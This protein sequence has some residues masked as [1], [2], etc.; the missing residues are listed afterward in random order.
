MTLEEKIKIAENTLKQ[1]NGDIVTNQARLS[2]IQNEIARL[3]KN[4]ELALEDK[5][6]ARMVQLDRE[7]AKRKETQDKQQK[8]LDDYM[9]RID[10]KDAEASAKVIDVSRREEN[11]REVS[12][13][14]KIDI[15]QFNKN[16]NDAETARE[17]QLL[18]LNATTIGQLEKDKAQDL[19]EKNLGEREASF[20][21]TLK[22]IEDKIT[23]NTHILAKVEETLDEVRTVKIS[24][25]E[26][27]R[28]IKEN[29][30]IMQKE[31]QAIIQLSAIK[32][33]IAKFETVKAKFEEER[34][35]ILQLSKNIEARDKVVA[36][37]EITASEKE[38]YQS[39]RERQ[40]QSKI[41]L[42]QKL[43]TGE[44]S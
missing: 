38:K 21:A 34:A 8:Y 12:D 29:L 44:K 14:L 19:R 41:D 10:A 11:V 31:K 33:D 26:E 32:D 25:S 36:E 7:Q 5:A 27:S 9:V 28:V 42:L 1:V 23:E 3:I 24:I 2:G 15:E 16:L 43:R 39:I 6:I 22:T 20:E 17:K 13:R 18:S 30:D 4:A 35:G 37:K 40:I